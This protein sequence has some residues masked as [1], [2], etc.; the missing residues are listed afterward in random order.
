MSPLL[1]AFTAIFVTGALLRTFGILTKTHAQLLAT[2]VFTVSLPATIIVSLD[3]ITLHATF[4][5]L[6]VAALLVLLFLLPCSWSIARFLKLSRPAQ[7]SFLVATGLINTVYFG[8]PVMLATFGE[9]GLGLAVLFD[10][11]L[12]LL[13]FT[14]IYGIAVWHG[15]VSASA[16]PATVR[17]FSAPP[18]WALGGMLVLKLVGAS[19]PAWLHDALTPLHLTTTPLA[20]LVL[21]LSIN[22]AAVRQTLPLALLGVV[23]RMGGGLLAGF[24][25]VVLLSLTNLERAIVI[26]SAALPA[27][28]NSVIFATEERLDEELAAAIVALSICLGIAFLPFLPQLSS[29][30]RG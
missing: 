21:G 20:S 22:A 1:Q 30:L 13:T 5:K 11:G 28:V 12:S 7:G 23:V 27:A 25:A 9:R 18:L 6:P 26:L 4:W 8:Y 24:A 19:L 10:L 16:R 17:F 29:L 14:V 15:S 2:I 3:L